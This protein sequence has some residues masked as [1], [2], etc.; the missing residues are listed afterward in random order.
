[1]VL[2]AKKE[3]SA[4]EAA[5][6]RALLAA[7]PEG[8]FVYA[9]DGECRSANEAASR[10]LGIPHHRLLKQNLREIDFWKTSG[11][12]D[13]AEETLNTGSARRLD[14]PYPPDSIA[15][16]WL[17]VRFTRVSLEGEATL[18]I[19]LSDVSERKAAEEALRASEQRYR[20]FFG[21]ANDGIILHDLEGRI[22]K[23]N[24]AVGERLGYTTEGLVGMDV[25]DIGAPE[26]AAL[27]PE[28][29]DELR[30]RGRAVFAISHRRRDGSIVPVEVSSRLIEEAGHELVLSLSRDVTER[31]QAEEVLRGSEERFRAMIEQFAEGFVLVDERGEITEWNQAMEQITGLARAQVLGRAYWEV[32]SQSAVPERRSAELCAR[33]KA[34]V[35]DALQ[36]GQSPYFGRVLEGTILRAD[37]ER[38]H[39][40]ETVF[41][42]TTED[43]L[44]IG[45]VIRDVTERKRMEE[46]LVHS[47]AHF[48]SLIENSTDLI[49][50]IDGAGIMR[51][52]SPSSQRVLGYLPQEMVGRSAFEFIHPDDVGA[53]QH[54]LAALLQG[55]PDLLDSTELRF[56][57]KDGSWRVLEVMAKKLVSPS[58]EVS[59]V[60]NSRDVTEHKQGEAALR[61]SEERFRGIFEQ[62]SVGIA[63]VDTDQLFLR[64]NPAFCTMLGYEENELVGKSIADVTAREDRQPSTQ[65]VG[66][67]Y[68]GK[69][70][71]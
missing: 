15:S 2:A 6:N 39:I 63:L 40:Q 20:A 65:E 12:L 52:Q 33:M 26:A 70:S 64:A 46:E 30:R 18:L 62:G 35:L 56:R 41:P 38:R 69:R 5:L 59:C 1:M 68:E 47:E 31:K 29:I 67:L 48:R 37:G 14:T 9:A 42:V 54:A 24:A 11:L 13:V 32:L 43:R 17:E 8:V 61:Q 4:P 51:F 44:N 28:H 58:G 55:E 45:H 49:A 16:R 22:L 71:T 60:L 25:R 57:H 50:V 10:L 19:F 53:S 21:S 3:E 7:L 27:Y 36:T 66:A 34:L 23:A